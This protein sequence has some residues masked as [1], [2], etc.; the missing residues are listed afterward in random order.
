MRRWRSRL[1]LG[2][3]VLLAAA[4]VAA[5][6]LATVPRVAAADVPVESAVRI[7]ASD[8]TPLAATLF[9]PPHP[10]GAVIVMP[11][12]WGMGAGE[13]A[14]IARRFA[15]HGDTVV[16]YAQRG[17]GRSGG[18]AD[19]A[20]AATVRDAGTVVDWA[21]AHTRAPT[22][23]VGMFGVSYGAGVSLLTAAHDPR[24]RAVAALSTWTDLG[25][26]LDPAHTPDTAAL[27]A[28]LGGATPTARLG[29]AL[30]AVHDALTGDT[31]R[32]DA[33][34]T[35]LSPSR[36]PQDY[37]ADLNRN[38][39]AVMIGNAFEDSIFP[40]AQLP[41]F[42][43]ALHGP[44][45]LELA[46]GDHG[47][48]EFA[49]LHGGDSRVVDDAETWLDTHLHV[50][51][52]T[53]P[54]GPP[55]AAARSGIVLVDPATGARYTLSAWPAA[56]PANRMGAPNSAHEFGPGMTT[57]WRAT[58]HSGTASPADS[59][60]ISFLDS[61][62]YHPPTVDMAAVQPGAAL[63]WS[64]PADPTAVRVCGSPRLRLLVGS[65]AGAATVYGYFYAVSPQQQAT[66]LSFAP[67]TVHT[68]ARLRPV[69]VTLQ[70]V[71][72]TVPAGDH[73]AVVVDA[74]DARYLSADP[75]AAVTVASTRAHPASFEVPEHA[76]A[77]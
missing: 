61:S 72:A 57:T 42:Y 35:A 48:P 25:A 23:R 12:S 14:P 74:A 29:P 2:A 63:T 26:S 27:T 69:T 58:L 17:F 60:P 1:V 68:A 34:L 22:P 56:A 8:G 24:I 7:T 71:C 67:V 43:A 77:G 55:S 33:E 45:R 41:P 20:G 47:G 32:L 10:D 40:A 76:A 49:A 18:L 54:S 6:R 21:L 75:G 19:F 64:A 11:A 36:S 31:V 73:L 9:R 38:G 70:P 30:T 52:R 51:P 62:H 39:T 44:R 28:L 3:V 4:G 5:A 16:A 46:P 15:A 59:G 66:L 13:Y 50:R 65:S 37:V 53:P